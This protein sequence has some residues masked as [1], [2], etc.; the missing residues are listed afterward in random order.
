MSHDVPPFNTSACTSNCFNISCSVR[1]SASPINKNLLFH[2]ELL[3]RWKIHYFHL[4]MS[5]CLI[6]VWKHVDP[7]VCI[8]LLLLIQRYPLFNMIPIRMIS[9]RAICFSTI[10]ISATGICST[11]GIK[12]PIWSISGCVLT[13]TSK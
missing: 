6:L 5:H 13:I 7:V 11:I 4:L 3:T 12:P 9:K 10:Y 8:V 2:I 1:T